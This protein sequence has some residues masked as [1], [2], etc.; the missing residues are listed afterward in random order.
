MDQLN[1]LDL[2]HPLIIAY[3]R[4]HVCYIQTS[5]LFFESFTPPPPPPVEKGNLAPPIPMNS[6]WVL[7]VLLFS[8]LNDR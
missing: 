7:P 5:I 2:S 6:I 4:E 8:I 1:Q 3:V